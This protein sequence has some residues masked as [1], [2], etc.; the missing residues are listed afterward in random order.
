MG[1]RHV[2]G[3]LSVD[4]FR[5]DVCPQMNQRFHGVYVTNIGRPMQG[6]EQVTVG[7]VDDASFFHQI[8]QNIDVAYACC[9]HER[10]TPIFVFDVQIHMMG[11]N[12]PFND[13]TTSVRHGQ[14]E[15]SISFFV[16]EFYTSSGFD[17]FL[18]QRQISNFTALIKWTLGEVL[19]FDAPILLL[20]YK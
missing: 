15:G 18:G 11:R 2:F 16:F 1:F 3:A 4:V 19:D 20:C 14:C 5:M 13:Q 10:C 7:F 8:F 17:K 9:V 12:Q 6:S